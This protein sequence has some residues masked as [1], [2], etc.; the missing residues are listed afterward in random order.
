MM[1]TSEFLPLEGKWPFGIGQVPPVDST[2]LPCS[3][4]CSVPSDA[5]ALFSNALPNGRR[6]GFRA[7]LS[8][9]VSCHI[10]WLVSWRALPCFSPEHTCRMS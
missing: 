4:W 8:C 9:F 5:Q 1:D 2:L 3:P 6:V 10:V 7:Q